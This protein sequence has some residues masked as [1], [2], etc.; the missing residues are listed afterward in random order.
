M[1]PLRPRFYLLQAQPNRRLYGLVIAKLKMQV[2]VVLDAAPLAAKQ[3]IRADEIQRAR[4][5]APLPHR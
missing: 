3:R 2:R 4:H 1:L 5:K